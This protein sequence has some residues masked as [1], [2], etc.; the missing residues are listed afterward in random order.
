MS[1]I[2]AIRKL[3]EIFP[4]MYKEGAGV[5]YTLAIFWQRFKILVIGSLIIV[6]MFTLAVNI[7]IA[8]AWLMKSFSL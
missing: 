6:S 5:K 7:L 2:K 4:P 1:L 8:H 3:Q